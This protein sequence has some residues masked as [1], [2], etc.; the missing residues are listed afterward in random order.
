[1]IEIN[2]LN[3]VFKDILF[4]YDENEILH[5]VTY[6]SKKHNSVKCNYEIYDKKLM[7]IVYTFKKW[8]SELKDFIYFVKMI[9]NYKNLKY[10]MS[11]K[12]LSHHQAHWSEFLS[13]FNY[14]IAYHF[15]KIDDKLNALTCCS[16]DLSKKRDT[17]NFQ[18]QYQH[19]T[20][21][22]TYVLNLNIV[23]NLVLDIFNIKIMKF[24]SQIIIL[25]SVQLHLF[26]VISA[27][28]QILVFMNLKIE[29]F[30]VEDVKSQLNQNILNLD[31]DSADTLTQTLWK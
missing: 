13:R 22:K 23:K 7:I 16:E 31:E 27:L 25:D 17:F 24:Q 18:Y 4:Q 26:S 6:F 8:W 30:N 14:H 2:A 28:L 3:Y 20:I 21:L 9:M 11:T 10:F 19:Q 29:K 1:M 12:Q 15:N 5:S